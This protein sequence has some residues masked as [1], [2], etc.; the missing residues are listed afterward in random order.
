MVHDDEKVW[1]GFWFGLVAGSLF[2]LFR[3]PRLRTGGVR[4]TLSG[5]K[6][7]ARD[8]LESLAPV[9]PLTDSIRRGKEAARQR[10]MMLEFGRRQD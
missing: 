9:D 4:E 1:S 6:D 10:Q 8:A 7:K 2:A 3:G 5:A